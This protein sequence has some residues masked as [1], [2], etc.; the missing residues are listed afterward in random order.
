MGGL[1]RMEKPDTSPELPKSA[2]VEKTFVHT[3]G[4]EQL[5]KLLS[6][7]RNSLQKRCFEMKQSAM[8]IEKDIASIDALLAELTIG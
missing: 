6:D 7:H 2:C 3:I 8:R 1:E 4:A 5:R